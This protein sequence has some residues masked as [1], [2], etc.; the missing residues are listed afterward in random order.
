MLLGNRTHAAKETI[1]MATKSKAKVVT[2]KHG[3]HLSVNGFRWRGH[4]VGTMRGVMAEDKYREPGYGPWTWLIPV[5]SVIE[6]DEIRAEVKALAEDPRIQAM[7]AS[8]PADVNVHSH[9]FL[10]AANHEA[11]RRGIDFRTIGSPAR[12]IAV[13]LGRAPIA[14]NLGDSIKIQG[15]GTWRIEATRY[16]GDHLSLVPVDA[17]AKRLAAKARPSPVS[18]RDLCS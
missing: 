12:A 6:S 2:V 9:S 3:D 15:N 8:L 18:E 5:A 7:A 11:H 1:N 4:Q 13:V 14:V 16:G 17:T 10:M